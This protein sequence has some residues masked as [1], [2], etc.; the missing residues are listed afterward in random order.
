MSVNRN[1]QPRHRQ[2]PTLRAFEAR[3]D[4]IQAE[5]A[6]VG[7]KSAQSSQKVQKVQKAAIA[8]AL[9]DLSEDD[10]EAILLLSLIR[11]R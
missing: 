1:V 2:A 4:E 8:P 11:R 10:E 3:Y 7:A 5:M 9:D 6:A